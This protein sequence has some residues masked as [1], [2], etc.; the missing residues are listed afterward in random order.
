[1]TLLISSR[2]IVGKLALG[3]FLGIVP[4]FAERPALG[5]EEVTLSY[6]ML[7]Q[8]LAV[9]DLKTYVETGTLDSA[10]IAYIQ[11]ATPE[12]LAQFRQILITP[13]PLD[14]AQTRQFLGTTAGK[15]I[16]QYLTGLVQGDIS[17][18]KVWAMR[19]AIAKATYHPQG[20]T[21]LGVLQE[22]PGKSMTVDLDRI[23]ELGMA[24]QALAQRTH[25]AI[26]HIH[27]QAQQEAT[28]GS[29]LPP[30]ID[31]IDQ[32]GIFTWETQTF[33]LTDRPRDR[34]IQVD[35]YLPIIKTPRPV[36]VISHGLG[37]DRSTLAYL[38]QHLA[39]YG[40]VVAVPEHEGS[41]WPH[42]QAFLNG[43]VDEL[44]APQEFIDR[45]QDVSYVLDHLEHLSE[46]GESLDGRLNLHQIGMVGQSLGGY[47]ALALAGAS[48]N[49]TALQDRCP[50]WQETLNPSLML[51]CKAQALSQSDP[52]LADSRI[53]AAIAISPIGSQLFGQEGLSQIQ[54]PIL[55]MAGSNDMLAPPL[56]EQI[57]P[58]R[59]LTTSDKYLAVMQGAN[60]YASIVASEALP[61]GPTVV[62]RYTAALSTAFLSTH[63][64][65]RSQYQGYLTAAYTQTLSQEPFSLSLVRSLPTP[66]VTTA[67][68][69]FPFTHP[70]IALG[71]SVQ[72]LGLL[73]FIRTRRCS[74]P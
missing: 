3:L 41:N 48:P 33:T 19:T 21:L 5:A 74:T 1:M 17:P 14:S 25:Q 22:F 31:R 44:M 55:M 4:T 40:F 51:Q 2:K 27:Q 53:K 28:L 13:A 61:P 36:I 73:Y 59:W 16:V 64:A 68:H 42:L 65:H 23:L 8:S 35:L 67:S 70:L 7:Q 49:F 54:I 30:S 29:Q 37:S 58:F 11:H 60:H 24:W 56:A 15:Q 20:L 12:Q 32:P 6:G 71:L 18:T 26:A 46:P 57:Q 66:T 39:S 34:T 10:S 50:N 63:V 69:S 9:D 45:P 43:Q 38:A 72:A 52:S 62:H 47:T